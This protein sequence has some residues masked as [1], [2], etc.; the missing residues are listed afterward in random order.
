MCWQPKSTCLY[1]VSKNATR[2]CVRAPELA[3][4]K[5]GSIINPT[6]YTAKVPKVYTLFEK[7]SRDK[8]Y[9]DFKEIF[10]MFR[11]Y[12]LETCLMRLWAFFQA[13]EVRSKKNFDV[14]IADPYLMNEE[15]LKMRKGAVHEELPSK[16]HATEQAI[17]NFLLVSYDPCNPFSE[18]TLLFL[19]LFL[20]ICFHVSNFIT[21]SW[22]RYVYL[23][24]RSN[25]WVLLVLRP[26]RC[27][28]YIL[29]SMKSPG[30]DW[31]LLKDLLDDC[32]FDWNTTGGHTLE[33]NNKGS[34]KKMIT[35]SWN[36]LSCTQQSPTSL[37]C[38]FYT[39]IHMAEFIRSAKC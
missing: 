37:T 8:I 25:H 4:N 2:Q 5:Q 18:F 11:L 36:T 15:N 1:P 29:D 33:K 23:V 3:N 28:C 6:Q 38:G 35:F 32:L 24:L 21:V 10:Y 31:S 20:H 34:G 22:S 7:F 17:K 19:Y 12:S 30:K 13:T 27:N 14:T 9:V 39:Y 16:F 26:Q